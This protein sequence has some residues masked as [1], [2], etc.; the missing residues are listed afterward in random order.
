MKRLQEFFTDGEYFSL[1][2]LMLFLWGNG[3][4]AMWIYTC[5]HTKT[6]AV[7]PESLIMVLGIFLTSKVVQSKIENPTP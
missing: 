5:L 3:I 4:L 2:R 1:M 7:I 6:L